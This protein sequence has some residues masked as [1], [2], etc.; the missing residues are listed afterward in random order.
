MSNLHKL[1]PR[2]QNPQYGIGMINISSV[3]NRYFTVAF[4]FE[5]F[6]LSFPRPSWDRA[7]RDFN[8]EH[9]QYC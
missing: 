4:Q 8:I 9:Y 1:G 3:T 2:R 7:L 6:V 5:F